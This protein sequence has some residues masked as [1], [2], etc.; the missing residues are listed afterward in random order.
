MD[1]KSKLLEEIALE[2]LEG[3]TISAL[4]TRLANV[5]P[6]FPLALDDDSKRFL[7]EIIVTHEEFKFYALPEARG[8]LV[9]FDRFQYTNAE[10]G[11]CVESADHP[12][13]IYPPKVIREGNIKGSCFAYFTREDVTGELRTEEGTITCS[14]ENAIKEWDDRLVIVASQEMRNTTLFGPEA[15]PSIDLPEKH[16]CLLERIGRARWQG[17][18]TQGKYSLQ[19]FKESSKTLFYWRKVLTRY[20]LV[21]VQTFNQ[22]L[23]KGSGTASHEAD[24]PGGPSSAWRMPRR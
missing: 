10:T 17:E 7:W 4:W 12:E 18:V 2:G 5:Q 19:V 22:K 23:L 3:I 9:I 21:T 11:I 20:D 1:F 6:E 13:D 24:L 14:L 8:K 16:F 15:D